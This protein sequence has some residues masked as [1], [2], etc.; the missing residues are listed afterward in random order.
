M[1]MRMYI[2]TYMCMYICVDVEVDVHVFVAMHICIYVYL[3]VC[4]Y[5]CMCF[6]L[7]TGIHYMYTCDLDC[8]SPLFSHLLGSENLHLLA[9]AC[10]ASA[11]PKLAV[12]A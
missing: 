11:A 5:V 10:A 2:Y 4:I 7:F 3:Y 12:S 8:G 6:C 1:Y 9:N